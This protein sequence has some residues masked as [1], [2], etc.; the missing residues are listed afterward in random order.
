MQL[1]VGPG[2]GKRLT[3]PLS[4]GYVGCFNSLHIIAIRY[5]YTRF[6]SRVVIGVVRNTSA[7]RIPSNV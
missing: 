2:N 5:P 6:E 3:P 7:E 4:G 1:D